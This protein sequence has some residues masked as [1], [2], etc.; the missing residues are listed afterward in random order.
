[1]IGIPKTTTKPR[2][3]NV[4]FCTWRTRW[5]WWWWV[6]NGYGVKCK[7]K[8]LQTIDTIFVNLNLKPSSFTWIY[9]TKKNYVELCML[10]LFTLPKCKGDWKKYMTKNVSV[11]GLCVYLC[12]WFTH[13]FYI[14]CM[15]INTY[16]HNTNYYNMINFLMSR[17]WLVLY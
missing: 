17:S 15:V 10:K 14:I 7:H 11:K 5:A 8:E 2:G 4:I 6:C 12:E 9:T 3:K 1:M 13:K 16:T